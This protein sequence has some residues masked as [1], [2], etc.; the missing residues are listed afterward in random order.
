MSADTRTG[1][2]FSKSLRLIF[3]IS[4][5]PDGV[6]VMDNDYFEFKAYRNLKGD[7]LMEDPDYEVVRCSDE[8]KGSIVRQE[9]FQWYEDSL[10]IKN[11]DNIIV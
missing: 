3:G 9:N 2:A 8:Y 7:I 6:D 11:M 5:L 4:Y 1:A 10:C